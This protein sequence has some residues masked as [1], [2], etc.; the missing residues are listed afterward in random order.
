MNKGLELVEATH[1]FAVP[2]GR[3]DIVIHPQSIIHSLVHY[4]DGSVL[5]Q[6]SEPDMRVPIAYALSYPARAPLTARP[7]DLVRLQSLTFEA[8][9]ETRFPALR[10]VRAAARAGSGATAA[11]NAANEEAV[12][13]FLKGRLGFAGIAAVTEAA[14]EAV[15][16][17]SLAS[18]AKSPSSLHEVALLDRE[19]RRCAALAIGRAAA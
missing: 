8:P 3:I 16:T 18:I 13:A 9:D 19:A 17:G 11:L 7:L 4:V 6:L 12:E 5:A 15:A 10:V 2:E 14:V 1:L